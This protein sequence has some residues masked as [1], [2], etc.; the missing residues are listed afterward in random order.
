VLLSWQ[1]L[2]RLVP[3]RLWQVLSCPTDLQA[4][5]ENGELRQ[6]TLSF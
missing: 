2:E 6:V 3:S 4:W 1:G 5:F